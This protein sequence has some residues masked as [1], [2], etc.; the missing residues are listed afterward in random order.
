MEDEEKIVRAIIEGG[1]ELTQDKLP[2]ITDFSRPKISRIVAD[3]ADRGI[4]TKTPQGR[5][6]KLQIEKEFYEK[7]KK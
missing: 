5:T 6:Q 2:E 4:L 7:V 3:L 1:G